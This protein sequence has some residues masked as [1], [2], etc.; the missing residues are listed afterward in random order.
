[1]TAILKEEPPELSTSGRNVPP[2]L[3]RIVDHC[4]EKSPE[5]RF[6][7]AK[8]L[9]FALSA[10]SGSGTAPALP[11]VEGR[12]RRRWVPWAAIAAIAT[13]VLLGAYLVVKRPAPAE[14]MQFAI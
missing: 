8:D 10:L 3:Q 7:T 9:A 12:R 11:S 6:Q 2:S 5:L 4:L 1:M 13:T 14:R